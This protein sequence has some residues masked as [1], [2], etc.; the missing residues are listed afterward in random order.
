MAKVTLAGARVS[1][2]FTQKELAEKMGVSRDSVMNW[3]SGKTEIRVPNL[4]L[5]CQMT[6]FDKDDILLPKTST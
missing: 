4:I 6:G 1:A 3:E 2:G 5:F